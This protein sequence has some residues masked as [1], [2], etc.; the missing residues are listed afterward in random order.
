LTAA[1]PAAR[2]FDDRGRPTGGDAAP[3][4]GVDPTADAGAAS[5]GAVVSS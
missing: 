4:A 5:I 2:E 1:R 3:V